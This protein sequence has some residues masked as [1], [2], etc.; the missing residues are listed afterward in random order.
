M[1]M[2]LQNRALLF[3]L[4]LEP[5]N[6]GASDGAS[7]SGSG[8][9]LEV[10]TPIDGEVLG[11]VQQ[12]GESDCERI[13]RAAQKAFSV[14]REIPAPKRGEIV[15]QLGQA[16][17]A[18]KEPLGKLVTLEMG[19][20][21]HEGLGEVQ[22]MIDICDYA[23]GQSRMLYGVQ[24]HSERPRHRLFEQWHPL[25]PI[26]IVSAFNF[27]VAVWSWNAA[28][29]LV[30]G[31]VC[32]WKPA[33]LA[34][35]SAIACQK[36]L[37]RVLG[38]NGLPAGISSLVVGKGSDVGERL[39]H[40]PR[41]PL[42]SYTG[43]TQIGRRIAQV[44]ASRFGRTIL[45][46][47]GNNAII[48]TAK[49]NL[50][51]ACQNV[52]FGAIGTAGQRCTTTRRVIVEGTVYD[53]FVTRL[54]EHYARVTIGNPLDPG[55]LMGPLVDRSAVEVMMNALETVRRQGGTILWGGERLQGHGHEGGC[56]V[57]PAVAEVEPSVAIVREETFA[58][59]LYV[60]KYQGE[61][62][63]AI[64]IQND[65]PQGLSS[66][67]FTGDL[68]EAE[69]FLSAAGS[70]SGIANVNVGTSGAEI[71]LAFGGEKE[72]G[73]GRESGSDAWKSYMRRQTNTVNWSE[74]TTLAQ[75]IKFE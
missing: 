8:P 55:C 11:E 19:K 66:A 1:G 48:V 70:D 4:G 22:E 63:R 61:L 16:L 43:S 39:I 58:P 26:G 42:I 6:A 34:P 27:P 67:I 40:D 37:E 15:R 28:I 49:A 46:L 41:I 74:A 18:N 64:A 21:I 69:T 45:E 17:R 7:W 9:V 23:C 13:V 72:T 75:G 3:A 50:E 59:I 5:V 56:Y 51:L 60:L 24:T 73:G 35:L 62:A 33:S 30:A 47:G 53:R 36:I 57:S 38:E 25:G 71:G 20:S 29:A 32:I 68:V 44:V 10:R 65:V 14:W 12:A 54:R 31:D 52:V 2:A